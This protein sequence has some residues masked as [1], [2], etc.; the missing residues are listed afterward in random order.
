DSN[1]LVKADVTYSPSVIATSISYAVIGVKGEKLN[2]N[3]YQVRALPRRIILPSELV[4]REN[5]R[6]FYVP[7][8][9]F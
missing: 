8:A 2:P 5:A 7:E 6:D 4:T 1:S 3:I 9:P